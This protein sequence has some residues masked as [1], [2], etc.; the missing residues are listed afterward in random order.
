M[1]GS[2]LR[3]LGVLVL[4]LA[5]LLAGAWQ[6]GVLAQPTVEGMDNSFGTVN[7]STTEIRTNLSVHNPNPVGLSFGGATVSY[8]VEM[9]DVEMASGQKKGISVGSGNDTLQFVTRMDNQKI[10][11]WWASHLR[12]G[13]ETTVSVGANVKTFGLSVSAPPVT[14]SVQ[15][16][17]L[18]SMNSDERREVNAD[19]PI[20]ETLGLNP[21]VVINETAASWGEVTESESPTEVQFTLY[22]PNPNPITVSELAYNVSMAEVHLG[23]GATQEAV[24]IPGGETETV[25]ATVVLENQRLDEWWVAHLHNDQR[26]TLRMSFDATVSVQDQRFRVPNVYTYETVVETAIFRN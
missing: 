10:P 18:S 4:S 6:M 13:E 16:D 21:V 22:N 3:V 11:A 5:V 25:N 9:N 15:T 7:Q 26:S 1:V 17:L 23:E 20:V 14:R 2:K 12:N 24:V 8:A 19:S